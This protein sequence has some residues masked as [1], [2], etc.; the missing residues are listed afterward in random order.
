MFIR[1]KYSLRKQTE[2]RINE[3]HAELSPGRLS[4]FK[5][6]FNRLSD[7]NSWWLVFLH[8]FAFFLLLMFGRLPLLG[9][10]KFTTKT[11]ETIIDQRTSNVATIISM[12]LA[13]IGLLL[14]NLAI[15]DSQTY[16]LLFLKSRLY[17]IIYYILSAIFFLI[18][19]STMRDTICPHWFNQA[20][21]AGTYLALSILILIGFLFSTI[22]NFAN[23]SNIQKIL[24]E[25]LIIETKSNIRK[26]LLV[27]YSQQKFLEIMNDFNIS[28]YTLSIALSKKTSTTAPAEPAKKENKE[29]LI[30]DIYTEKLQKKLRED[31]SGTQRYYTSVLALN[32]ITK[33]YDSY[34]WPNTAVSSNKSINLL[35]CLSLKKATKMVKNSNEYQQYFD[36]KLEEQT[37][38]GKHAKVAEILDLYLEI[39]LIQMRHR[40]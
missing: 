25:E 27:Q 35:S 14:S 1:P 10:I 32:T 22:I 15:K 30:A 8:V 7:K 9:F 17:F 37:A 24:K 6:Y 29:K 28:E 38:E 23:S 5:Q 16:K 40:S 13:V 18:I 4:L 3:D 21:L 33:D 11:A 39:Y 19:V 31:K 26:N 12:T 20:V 36:K 2:L 34:V